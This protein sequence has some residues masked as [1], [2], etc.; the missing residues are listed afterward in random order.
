V[1]RFRRPGGVEW[2]EKATT[3]VAVGLC[4]LGFLAVFLGWNGAAGKDYVSGQFPYLISGGVT[5]LGLILV[6]LTVVL[7]ETR[8]RDTARLHA[9]L[10]EL[11]ESLGVDR[12]RAGPTAVPDGSDLVIAGRS[13]YHVPT[14]RLVE[15]RGDLQAMS[16]ADATERG[17][18]PC[19][20]CEPQAA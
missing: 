4:A 10:D 15:G 19:R 3:Y 18:A 7:V 16:P 11:F 13:T 1:P 2:S 9:K 14:C 20:I 6:G 5:G 17:L 12:G 8:R